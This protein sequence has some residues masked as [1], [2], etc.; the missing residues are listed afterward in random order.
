MNSFR[1]RAF[2]A[3]FLVV[4]SR[5]QVIFAGNFDGNI[6]APVEL[7]QLFNRLTLIRNCVVFCEQNH[8]F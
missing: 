6:A 7:K 2:Q 8:G 5:N 1:V 3:D 4:N